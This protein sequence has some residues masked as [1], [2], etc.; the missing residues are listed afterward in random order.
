MDF[1]AALSPELLEADVLRDGRA[2]GSSFNFRLAMAQIDGV[3]YKYVCC[4]GKC[5][6]SPST[7]GKPDADGYTRL[8]FDTAADPFDMVDLKAKLPKVAETLRKELPV[9]HGFHCAKPAAA[10]VEAA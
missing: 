5:P 7:A 6:G 8:L 10:L 4:Q 2:T 1:G 3:P 9:V